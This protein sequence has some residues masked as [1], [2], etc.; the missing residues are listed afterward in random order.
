MF[1]IIKTVIDSNHYEL[2]D[3]LK[4]IDKTW[5]EGK[6]SDDERN[7]LVE[8]AQGKAN[9][10]NSIDV[11]RKLEELDKRVRALEA[12]R[13]EETEDGSEGETEEVTYP[14]YVAG[15]WYR[16]GDIV[17]FDGNAYRCVAP[18]GQTCVWSPAEYPLFWETV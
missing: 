14:D 10:Q 6:L 18:E 11:I 5:F 3:I 13:K 9:P 1:N 4:K 8:S 16:N 15:T 2:A 17:M 7:L 12:E